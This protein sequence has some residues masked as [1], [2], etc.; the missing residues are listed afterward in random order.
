VKLVV[1]EWLWADLAGEN[2]QKRQSESH[3]VLLQVLQKCDQFVTVAGSQFLRTFWDFCRS[4]RTPLHK[5]TIK[6][7]TDSFAYNPQKLLLC[8]QIEGA[9]RLAMPTGPLAKTTCI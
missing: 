8:A 4:A 5:K 1:D 2:T 6:M 9:G 3:R 7:F